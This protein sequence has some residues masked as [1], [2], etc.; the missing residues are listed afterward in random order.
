[1]TLTAAA[2]D[3]LA[4]RLPQPTYARTPYLTGRPFPHYVTQA[5]DESAARIAALGFPP[6][7]DPRWHTFDGE[8]EHGKQEGR[9]EIAGEPVEFVHAQLASGW[10]VAWLREL[11]RIEDLVADPHRIGGGIH[12]SGPEARLAMHVDFNV[13]PLDPGLLRAVNVILFVSATVRPYGD[14]QLSL[15]SGPAEHIEPAPGR[16]VVFPARDDCY[17]GHP[18]PMPRGNPP[19]RQSI[20]AYYYRPIQPGTVE[21]HSTR[22]L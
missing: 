18:Q 21:A 5:V 8:L 10:F 6:P 1:M 16:L 9:A 12:Q 7:D 3:A 17:H 15:G 19:L 11:T 2:L 4:L 14:L 13:H 20:P 22:F